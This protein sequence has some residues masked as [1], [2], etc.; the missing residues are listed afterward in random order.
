MPPNYPPWE[1]YLQ[2]GRTKIF[3]SPFKKLTVIWTWPLTVLVKASI[4]SAI[5]IKKTKYT[6]G[7]V[8]QWGEVKSKKSKKEAAQKAKA[9]T[10]P[11]NNNTSSST[12]SFAPPPSNTTTQRTY[13]GNNDRPKRGKF[14][15]K[16]CYCIGRGFF[17]TCA[18]AFFIRWSTRWT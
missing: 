7:H 13:K 6:I 12:I 1:S 8:S 9:A 11:N 10:V 18:D 17:L 14:C 2:T 3:Y 16:G 4:G 15:L 5:V